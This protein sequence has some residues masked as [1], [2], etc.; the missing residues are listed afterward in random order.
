[1]DLLRSEWI[2][3]RTIRVTYVLTIIAGVFPLLIVVLV[4]ALADNVIDI[5]GSDLVSMVTQSMVLSALLLGVVSTLS[6]TNEYGNGT[7][8]VSFAA[9]PNRRKVLVAKGVVALA[10]SMAI[11]TI[12]MLVAFA[13]G[14]TILNNRD[15]ILSFDSH[16]NSAMMG[17]VLLS[18]M[19]CLLGYGVGLIIRNSAASVTLLVLWPLLL[20]NLARIV[21]A[22]AKV[23][24]PT[25]WLP[26]QSALRMVS[27]PEFSSDESSRLAAGIPLAIVV[28]VLVA[29]GIMINER[30]DA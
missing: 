21:L 6:I 24:D 15:A 11:T 1:M 4:A 23:K 2:K 7:I 19:L 5:T 29:V 13:T 20:E 3:L 9:T 27:T 28:I 14:S 22:V 16:T 17:L 10:F 26:Y 30:R 12:V 25:V 18:G 8:R